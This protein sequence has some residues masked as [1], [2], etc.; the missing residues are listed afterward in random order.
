MKKYIFGIDSRK[1]QLGF[2]AVGVGIIMAFPL[3][4]NFTEWALYTGALFTAMGVGIQSDKKIE[5]KNLFDEAK[6]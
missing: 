1:I 5:S 4:A 3:K 2:L 6:K